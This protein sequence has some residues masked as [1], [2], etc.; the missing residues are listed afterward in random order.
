MAGKCSICGGK[1]GLVI[2][3]GMKDGTICNACYDKLF[4]VIDTLKLDKQVS[5]FT[6]DGAKE[7]I[8]NFNIAKE[9]SPG[10]KRVIDSE[11]PDENGILK[12]VYCQKPMK[13]GIAHSTGIK[14]GRICNDCFNR[15]HT[16]KQFVPNAPLELKNY[17]V[18]DLDLLF[19]EYEKYKDNLSADKKAIIEA[20]EKNESKGLGI[21]QLFRDLGDEGLKRKAD[22]AIENA[23]KEEQEKRKPHIQRIEHQNPISPIDQQTIAL[24]EAEAEKYA[25]EQSKAF[26]TGSGDQK[27]ASFMSALQYGSSIDDKINAIKS[28]YIWYEDVTIPPEIDPSIPIHV[29]EDAIR[30]RIYGNRYTI[31]TEKNK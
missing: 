30:R 19:A 28:K 29:D 31:I 12:C 5:D 10:M 27:A 20:E 22:K 21:G 8:K 16:A 18:K 23:Y 1:L 13:K 15:F 17:T 26:A 11:K 14:Q 24:L 4:Y 6:V 9:K 2:K 7:L 3:F 25:A